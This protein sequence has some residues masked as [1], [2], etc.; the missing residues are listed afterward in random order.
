MTPKTNPTYCLGNPFNTKFVDIN[1]S[2]NV[3]FND[4]IKQSKSAKNEFLFQKTVK[5]VIYCSNSFYE[6]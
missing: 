4:P 1:P 2:K 3:E 5:I 6:S